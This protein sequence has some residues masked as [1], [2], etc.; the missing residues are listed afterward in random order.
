[1]SSYP[2]G[3]TESCWAA[4][5]MF[6]HLCAMNAQRPDEAKGKHQQW[7]NVG[8]GFPKQLSKQPLAL[9]DAEKKKIFMLKLQVKLSLLQ[10]LLQVLAPE[11]LVTTV[12][13]RSSPP[14]LENPLSVF[15]SNFA[16]ACPAVLWS[17]WSTL[18]IL[19]NFQRNG[20][21]FCL[22][23]RHRIKQRHELGLGRT[24]T[25]SK[26]RVWYSCHLEVNKK[27]FQKPHCNYEIETKEESELSPAWPI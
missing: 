16:V 6:K 1:M 3:Q 7:T 18:H 14:I 15:V 20:N 2:A 12:L 13:T 8:P 21:L 10:S 24:P 23:N 4:I 27:W 26:P 19:H 17:V 25:W 9:D 11:Q 5:L 22:Y